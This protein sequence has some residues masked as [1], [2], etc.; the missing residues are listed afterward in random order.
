MGVIAI[1]IQTTN[2]R[3]D[4]CGVMYTVP[5][6]PRLV[7]AVRRCQECNEKALQIVA[8]DGAVRESASPDRGW[9]A[10]PPGASPHH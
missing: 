6:E 3:C 9:S 4:Q 8:A 1:G 7:M 10:T 5:I 2:V